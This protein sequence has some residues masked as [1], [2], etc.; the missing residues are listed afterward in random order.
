MPN[1]DPLYLG[2]DLGT[3]GVRAVVVT[4]DG[5]IVADA[6]SPFTS[7]DVN[8][9]GDIHEQDARSWW[10][11]VAMAVTQF[12]LS[13]LDAGYSIEQIRAIAVDGTSGTIVP[14]DEFGYVLGPA[15]MYNDGRAVAEAEELTELAQAAGSDV[16]I[17]PSYAAARIRWFQKHEPDVF[18]RTY[19]FAHQADYIQWLMLGCRCPDARQHVFP[20]RPFTDYSNALKTGYD[21]ANECWPDWLLNIEGVSDRLPRVVPPG[22]AVGNLD[23]EDLRCFRYAHHDIQIITG[24][25]DGTAGFLASG[26][27]NLGDDNTTLG[28]TLVFKRIADQP[29]N[30]ELVYS[31]KLPGNRWLPGAASNTGGEWIRQQFADADLKALDAQAAALLPIDVLAYPLAHTGER[32]PFKNADATGFIELLDQ[33]SSI[34]LNNPAVRYRRHAARHRAFRTPLLRTTQRTNQHD[35]RPTRRHLR[36]RRRREE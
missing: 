35:R 10:P 1:P 16:V 18:E 7:D 30:N 32:F 6:N 3:G 12:E 31:H 9:H 4:G 13:L 11:M 33:A 23:K 26:A 20:A 5:E 25:S 17:S 34:D 14:I 36:D 24:C 29:V 8:Q 19:C 27:K 15:L 21:L 22:T 2:I 28:T